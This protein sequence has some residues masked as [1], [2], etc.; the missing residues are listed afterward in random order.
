MYKIIIADDEPF[1]IKGLKVILDWGS[2]NIEIVGEAENGRQ[3]MELIKAQNPDIVISD[4]EMP[5]LNG[6]DIVRF[7][8]EQKLKTKVLLLSAY[9]EFSYAKDAIS[10]GA[11]DYLVKPVTKED[12]TLAIKRTIAMIEKE[13]ASINLNEDLKEE[14]AKT[15]SKNAEISYESIFAK[16]KAQNIS[17]ERKIFVGIC[18]SL[19][20]ESTKAVSN[21]N[22]FELLRFA[23][24][25][26]IQDYLE[27][28]KI[29]VI[30]K[31][32]DKYSNAILALP[33]ENN[34]SIIQEK[35]SELRRMLY[36]QY[37]AKINIGIGDFSQEIEKA[38]YLYKT[39]KFSSELYYFRQEDTIFY[40]SINKE[41]YHS[42]EE[43]ESSI[44]QL[45]KSVISRDK[46]WKENYDTCFETIESIHYGNRYAAENKVSILLIDLC[47][48]LKEYK[49]LF[50]EEEEELEKMIQKVRFQSSYAKLKNHILKNLEIILE[51]VY[52]SPAN[53][54]A[55]IIGQVKKYIKEH[56]AKDISLEQ[57]AGMVYM[58]RYY[59]SSFFKKETGQNFKKYLVEVRMAEAK[60][61]LLEGT[62]KTYEIA[63]LVGYKDVRS[64][65]DK[66]K[67]VYGETTGAF[68][69]KE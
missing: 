49:M 14:N 60:K 9:Q 57:M 41:Y 17:F 40:E 24:F 43:L 32:N 25:K 13:N 67:E 38:N 20:E 65:S 34:H 47:R 62:L 12:L 8:Q 66:F 30:V 2:L 58:N 4:I 36:A 26:S 31:R 1:I 21:H 63:E 42:M 19:S 64:F 45:L 54:E 69:K 37:E 39:A 11:I 29:G 6:V 33:A 44:Q 5:E 53:N 56:Y 3:L 50:V 10:Y 61:L 35:I 16:L 46:N 59:F 68:K 15:I 27:N 23:I 51:K 52:A 48:E 18:F 55:L 22:K 7:V 28:Q